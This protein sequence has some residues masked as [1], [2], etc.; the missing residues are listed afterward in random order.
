MLRQV[1]S[2]IFDSFAG[3]SGII[4]TECEEK[5]A[6]LQ[7]ASK[8]AE[9][10]VL[11]GCGT[12]GR[13]CHLVANELNAMRNN[14]NIHCASMAGGAAAL[15]MSD[16]LPEDDPVAGARDLDA[17]IGQISP[18]NTLVIV[19]SC[20]LSA[21]YCA[22]ALLHARQVR[23]CQT[24][25]AI[26]FNRPEAARTVLFRKALAEATDI[27]ITPILGPEAIA[28]SSRMKGGTAAYVILHAALGNTDVATFRD[29]IQR[30]FYG[31]RELMAALRDI[32]D[33]TRDGRVLF[34]TTNP[35]LAL[36]CNFACTEMVDTFGF[37]R[38]HF[39][40][41]VAPTASQVPAALGIADNAWQAALDTHPH[42]R[43]L[44]ELSADTQRPLAAN[45]NAI[46]VGS[47][48]LPVTTPLAAK[49]ALDAITTWLG[50]RAGFVRRNRMINLTVA[51]AKLH[52]RAIA[53]ISE[54]CGVSLDA[55]TRALRRA[56]HGSDAAAGAPDVERDVR[57]ATPQRLVVPRAMAIA[58]RPAPL[59]GVVEGA[60]GP[61]WSD[62]DRLRIIELM[63]RASRDAAQWASAAA[64]DEARPLNCYL[65]G[66]KDDDGTRLTWRDPLG[67]AAVAQLRQTAQRC[68]VHGIQ[69]V[70]AL[71][72]GG[73]VMFELTERDVADLRAR[74][75]QLRDA[76]KVHGAAV[77]FDD[78][79]LP[80]GDAASAAW[81]AAAQTQARAC[82]AILD[83]WPDVPLV[84]LCPSAYHAN[85][86]RP[87][88]D[89]YFTALGE[90]LS[91]RVDVLW[92]GDQIVSRVILRASVA[93][94]NRLL[95]RR[96]L[97]WDNVSTNDYDVTRAF[98]AP[99]ELRSP[100]LL[101]G[102]D[103]A[104]HVRGVLLNN[105]VSAALFDV[106]LMSLAHFAADPLKYSPHALRAPLCAAW[107]SVHGMAP[108]STEL[109]LDL[110]ATPF[111][112]GVV[113]PRICA[114]LD[115]LLAGGGGN[116]APVR[117]D[118]ERIVR[119]YDEVIGCQSRAL[120]AALHAVLWPL[121]EEALL[122]VRLLNRPAA[123]WRAPTRDAD[124]DA[125]AHVW[126][127]GPYR[128]LARHVAR[129]PVDGARVV[130]RAS[131]TADRFAIERF[132]GA[133]H[134]VAAL[135]H[136][137]VATGDEGRDGTALLDD[138]PDAYPD[139]FVQPYINELALV[140]VD[141]SNDNAVVGYC[142]GVADSVAHFAQCR[143]GA[144][145]A[146]ASVKP[147]VA[148]TTPAS[149]MRHA[150]WRDVHGLEPIDGVQRQFYATHPAHLH[151]DMLAVAQGHGLG[152][153]LVPRMLAQLR[154]AGARGV[155][156][157]CA[158]SNE[159]ARRLYE[160][161]GM[162]TLFENADDCVMG[163]QFNT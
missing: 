131:G 1:D 33:R 103:D 123:Q 65:Y 122:Q 86:P 59:F 35:A 62:A 52:E 144:W 97:I 14:S 129:E 9:R 108:E 145:L 24:T 11:M 56:I 71:H 125:G 63:A 4:D 139:V 162:R 43:E 106:P 90:Q 69:F 153:V 127:G 102:G 133:R 70:V 89:A 73:D 76:C 30:Q 19:V 124:V 148:P 25:C 163:I 74:V 104:P 26:G 117:A 94:I 13:M 51:N 113:V 44:R 147:T 45:D 48:Q 161:H 87:Q 53:L 160:Q 154:D 58:S 137:C 88:T 135:R 16:E 81:C 132:D 82:R 157:V 115:R 155:H 72:I 57:A 23:R 140:V 34:S 109:L 75:R 95:R 121:K 84:M 85:D 10:I 101:C 119:L 20:G 111:D 134:P 77:F 159:R 91:P 55:A 40:A 68:A 49:L 41:V 66:P 120:A 156:L 142:L 27:A 146:Q 93:K 83:E 143:S 36:S 38:N 100:S 130:L 39:G 128:R 99:I 92:T 5:I 2:Q 98:L 64:A 151:I 18:D 126:R 37:E 54:L 141:R 3:Q 96:V 149:R 6:L 17:A 107:R 61:L 21:D 110:C 15:C 67:D 136:I 158:P 114:R 7:I 150:I 47:P 112:V 28:G 12:S 116:A 42:D 118:L 46:V 80:L 152:Q 78:V 29:Q 50:V 60:Y 22:G 79:N 138:D 31:S 105:P 8:R 32:L